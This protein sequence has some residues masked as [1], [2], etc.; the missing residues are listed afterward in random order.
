VSDLLLSND[1]IY[2]NLYFNKKLYFEAILQA[3]ILDK[4]T[5]VSTGD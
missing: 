1:K 3:I 4:N 2:G 5:F